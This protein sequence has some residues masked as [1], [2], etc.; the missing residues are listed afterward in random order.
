VTD[1]RRLAAALRTAASIRKPVQVLVAAVIGWRRNATGDQ[2]TALAYMSLLSL[3]PLAAASSVL[4]SAVF[5]GDAGLA[6]VIART[7]P[8]DSPQLVEKLRDL[9]GKA[10][11][12]AG[13]GTLFFF[14][15]AFQAWH[16][17]E[18]SIN[19]V[20]HIRSRRRL[21][22]RIATFALVM[23]WGP[24]VLVF[25]FNLRLVFRAT[26]LG[27]RGWN[28]GIGAG[29]FFLVSALAF[30]MIHWRAPNARVRIVP[31]LAGGFAA[32]LGM[33]AIRFVLARPWHFLADIRHV[34]GS[35][36]LALLLTLALHLFWTW[37]LFT[38]EIV[39]AWQRAGRIPARHF[40]ALPPPDD[41]GALALRLA[42][43]VAEAEVRN[44]PPRDSDGWS[45]FLEAPAD[46]IARVALRLERAGIFRPEG[47]EGVIRTTRDPRRIS[48]LEAWNGVAGPKAP[49][50]P[51]EILL[52]DIDRARERLL[53]GRNLLGEPLGD[54]TST[55]CRDG[56]GLVED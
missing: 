2:A 21:A 17:V 56:S 33:A 37:F 20:W 18:A 42:A 28:A 32:A 39:H 19:R 3:V 8:Y 55:G 6:D 45:D 35:L 11:A 5:G 50:G 26:A 22:T 31:A 40:G 53:M 10:R 7:L 36:A 14:I 29:T 54:P 13:W 38:V 24:I 41:D 12:G 25:F 16:R 47:V 51:G 34:Y 27:G 43:A 15:V 44:A 49:S 52:S 23:F 4:L 48:A 9:V 30:T 1:L 46:D